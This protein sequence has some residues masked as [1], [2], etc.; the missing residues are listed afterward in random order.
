MLG[1]L[2]LSVVRP[3]NQRDR[4]WTY[5]ASIL[6]EPMLRR[7]GTESMARLQP[8]GRNRRSRH[9]IGPVLCFNGRPNDGLGGRP[10]SSK[11]TRFSRVREFLFVRFD[12]VLKRSFDRIFR[13]VAC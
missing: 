13:L 6:K 1:E 8:L 3:L 11:W 5:L 10:I 12:L 4:L 2:G 9:S 7:R